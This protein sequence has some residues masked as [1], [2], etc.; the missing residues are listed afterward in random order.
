MTDVAL[1]EALHKAECGFLMVGQNV[2]L[3]R[4]TAT[5]CTVVL[6][7]FKQE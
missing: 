1:A 4:T 5:Y 7:R 2:P 6:T 3:E